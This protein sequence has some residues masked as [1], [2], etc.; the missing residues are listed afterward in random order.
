MTDPF[1][2]TATSNGETREFEAQL[3][4]MGYTH[5]FSVKLNDIPLFFERD[6]EGRYRAIVSMEELD[7]H[8]LAKDKHWLPAIAAAIEE[9]LA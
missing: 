3:Q 8:Q 5:R 6:E 9:I 7:K 1:L 2:I 4:L